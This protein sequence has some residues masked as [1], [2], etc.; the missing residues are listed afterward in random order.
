VLQGAGRDD[1]PSDNMLL[2]DCERT[3]CSPGCGGTVRGKTSGIRLRCIYILPVLSN[4]GGL[5]ST[6]GIATRYTLDGPKFESRWRRNFPCRPDRTLG[7][8]VSCTIRTPTFPGIKRT[9]HGVDQSFP[10]S[11]R[12]EFKLALFGTVKAKG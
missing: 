8:P 10:F 1:S 2:R 7:H 4:S 5:D 6:V 12:K 3:N 9:G 11:D